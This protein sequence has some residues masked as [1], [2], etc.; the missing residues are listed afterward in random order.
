MPSY[1]ENL[2][3]EIILLIF[4]FLNCKDCA[5][6]KQVCKK[7]SN[8]LN[9]I[10]EK[11][12]NPELILNKTDRIVIGISSDGNKIAYDYSPHMNDD[13]K[14]TIKIFDNKTGKCIIL[15]D[16]IDRIFIAYFFDNDKKIIILFSYFIEIWD[17][18]EAKKIWWYSPSL[19]SIPYGE[20]CLSRNKEKIAIAFFYMGCGDRFIE[21]LDLKKY[22]ISDTISMGKKN[23]TSMVFSS[24]GKCIA[25]AIEG[26]ENKIINLETNE[27]YT[28]CNKSTIFDMVF[29][30][31]D[32]KLIIANGDKIDN[33]EIWNLEKNNIEITLKGHKD[34]V[35][36]I[37]LFSNERKV[38][39]ASLDKTLKIWDI[40]DGS[41]FF[42]IDIEIKIYK[43]LRVVSEKDTNYE[44]I[45]CI[46]WNSTERFEINTWKIST[47][48]LHP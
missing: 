24:N 43:F 19:S 21:I 23:P 10:C 38:I 1:L 34:V 16:S 41:C 47:C 6:L 18:D 20:S 32:K 17:I 35:K 25:I 26:Y 9:D 40:M 3:N 14:K 42:T 15:T 5:I 8:L 4:S 39:S 7:F 37:A 22:E 30:S 33:L 48:R 12:I 28:I 29:F 13:Q 27:R 11:P 44:K 2:P 31:S 46:F 36:G 45:I